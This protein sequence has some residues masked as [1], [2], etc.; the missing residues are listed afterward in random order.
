MSELATL[1]LGAEVEFGLEVALN[2]YRIILEARTAPV[3]PHHPSYLGSSP[4]RLV[5]L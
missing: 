2:P 3:P 1:T 5:T 4:V